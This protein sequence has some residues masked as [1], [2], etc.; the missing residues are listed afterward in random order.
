MSGDIASRLVD[1][2]FDGWGVLLIFL[3]LIPPVLNLRLKFGAR[4]GRWF[5]R[6]WRVASPSAS[7]PASAHGNRISQPSTRQKKN[8]LLKIKRPAKPGV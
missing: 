1:F 8:K 7:S 5:M 3:F 4:F 6:I 2:L